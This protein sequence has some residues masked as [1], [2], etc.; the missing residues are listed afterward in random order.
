MWLSVT[1]RLGSG[2]HSPL[3]GSS[4]RPEEPGLREERKRALKVGP[5]VVFSP[6]LTT[7]AQ[8]VLTPY[9]PSRVRGNRSAL[10]EPHHSYSRNQMESKRNDSDIKSKCN[11]QFCCEKHFLT[12]RKTSFA[13]FKVRKDLRYSTVIIDNIILNILLL[14]V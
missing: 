1:P 12:F 14:P 6:F 7:P 9:P 8:Q 5:S 2:T 11:M 10:W 3:A 13:V 4:R